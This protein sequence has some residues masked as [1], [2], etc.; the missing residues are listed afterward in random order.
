MTDNSLQIET[1]L[2]PKAYEVL[3][4]LV[5]R[6]RNVEG[7][8][9]MILHDIQESLGYVPREWAMELS[10]MINVRLARIYE[11]LTFYH[12]FK[13]KP[14]GKHSVQ[15]CLGT[16][17][18]IKGSQGIVDTLKSKFGFVVGEATP[19][20]EFQL[21]VIRCIGACGIAP[22]V[23]VDKETIGKCT[24]EKITAKIESLKAS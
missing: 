2:D 7:S 6:W 23:I 8:L 24:P 11:V 16:A 21:D 3:E 15:V 13:L 22:A 20:R 9:I 10:R 14:Q 1:K 5:K 18:H 12:Y 4:K 19:D 17:C